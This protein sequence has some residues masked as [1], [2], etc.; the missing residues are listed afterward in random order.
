MGFEACYKCV[1]MLEVENLEEI[2]S[3]IS[4]I[5]KMNIL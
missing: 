4:K 1:Y 2:K 5:E 3:S